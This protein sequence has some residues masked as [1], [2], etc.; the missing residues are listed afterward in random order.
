MD[1]EA[2]AV[3][4]IEPSDVDDEHTGKDNQEASVSQQ[5][6]VARHLMLF[7]YNTVSSFGPLILWK[8]NDRSFNYDIFT[9][10]K[11]S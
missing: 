9:L 10:L 5:A 2:P 7:N 1:G 4:K 11:S 6:A 8:L 3:V